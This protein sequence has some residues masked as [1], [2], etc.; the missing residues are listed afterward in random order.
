[1]IKE[2]SHDFLIEICKKLSGVQRVILAGGE[3]TLRDDL[4]EI[5]SELSKDVE[6]VAMAS[7]AVLVTPSLAA[8]LKKSLAYVDITIDGTREIHNKIRGHYDQVLR[9]IR[10]FV[11]AGVDVSLVSVLL[12]DNVSAILDV[13]KT[14][15]EL[16]A[17]KLKILTPIRKGRG[18]NIVDRGLAPSELKELF[19]EIRDAKAKNGWKVRITLVDWEKVLPCYRESCPTI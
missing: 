12:S 2:P 6:V 4:P 7:N 3:P 13:C 14:A 17:K 9:G 10:N 11:E 5:A 8:A 19:D 1:M 18:A 16:S 15:N